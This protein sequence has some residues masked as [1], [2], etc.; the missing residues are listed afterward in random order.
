MKFLLEKPANFN[1][2]KRVIIESEDLGLDST[3]TE[4]FGK[5]KGEPITLEQ[6]QEVLKGF[7]D[8]NEI[9]CVGCCTFSKGGLLGQRAIFY[10][11]A[12][13]IL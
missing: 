13:T 10:S 7:K 11:L 5:L 2:I 12:A 8:N 9:L 6:S 4:K 3:L 1:D